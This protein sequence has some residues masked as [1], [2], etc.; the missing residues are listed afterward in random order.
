M[1]QRPSVLLVDE[2]E[3]E[4]VS[5]LL[6]ELRADTARVGGSV[7]PEE[8]PWPSR[9]L[10]ASARRALALGPGPPSGPG[11]FMMIAIADDHSKSLRTLLRRMG[12]NYLVRRP[13]HPEALK[14]LFLH[15][16]YSGRERRSASRFPVGC[17][18]ACHTGWRRWY[19]TLAEISPTGCRLLAP[20]I[21]EVGRRLAVR[22][23]RKLGKRRRLTLRGRVVRSTRR[24][25]ETSSLFPRCVLDCPAGRVRC[26]KCL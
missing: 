8:W 18:V 5:Q 25:P 24:G 19:A 11:G 9:L 16:L 1:V 17:R 7:R 23:P 12:F 14:L 20:R 2:G 26:L 3:L 10:I 21:V 22:V 13:V 15:A 6:V 4:D